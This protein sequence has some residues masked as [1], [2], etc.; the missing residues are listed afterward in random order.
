MHSA[1]WLMVGALLAATPGLAT[2][3]GGTT[4][5]SSATS[6]LEQ[7]G[8]GLCADACETLV[9]CGMSGGSTCA[10]SGSS[11]AAEP[12]CTCEEPSAGR[13]AESCTEDIDELLE[14]APACADELLSLLDC[15][16]GAACEDARCETARERLE[17]CEDETDRDDVKEVRGARDGV[18]CDEGFGSGSTGGPPL[19]GE[20]VCE[21]GFGGCSDGHD[22]RASC[23]ARSDG[24][25]DCVCLVDGLI[26]GQF[27]SDGTCTH[28][29]DFLNEVCGWNL[30][31]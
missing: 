23:V 3:C 14:D 27:S 5:G 16:A 20:P 19:Q 21:Q 8:A 31:L 15:V 18:T 25:T 2:A 28:G 17:E 10:C 24:G 22:Y 13:C 7:D 29:A 11:D 30:L 4:T 6:R 12:T 26:G 9:A 1:R